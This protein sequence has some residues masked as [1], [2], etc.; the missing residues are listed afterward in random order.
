MWAACGFNASLFEGNQ[1]AGVREAWRLALFGVLSPLGRMV[2]V[3]LLGALL[4][5]QAWW[6]PDGTKGQ[7]RGR[8][9]RL[10]GTAG[11]RP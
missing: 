4:L 10:V 6:G 2:P 1:A 11:L 5:T 9:A 8:D 3:G 7:A